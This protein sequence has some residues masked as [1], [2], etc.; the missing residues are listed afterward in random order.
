VSIGIC[1]NFVADRCHILI[2]LDREKGGC[3]I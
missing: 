1:D 2:F 3:D